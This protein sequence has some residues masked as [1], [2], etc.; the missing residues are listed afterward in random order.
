MGETGTMNVG[1][2]RIEVRRAL[3]SVSPGKSP[4]EMDNAYM[5]GDL[6]VKAAVATAAFEELQEQV[7]LAEA[8]QKG[9]NLNICARCGDEISAARRIARPKSRICTAC[10]QEQEEA[11]SS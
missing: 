6:Q 10:K 8:V 3:R 5:D 2:E 9:E 4:D 11:A 1:Q 7:A